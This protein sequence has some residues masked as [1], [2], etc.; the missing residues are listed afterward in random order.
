VILLPRMRILRAVLHL[1]KLILALA[2]HLHLQ[3][4][5]LY[6]WLLATLRLLYQVTARELTAGRRRIFRVGGCWLF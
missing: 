6:F 1:H 5:L 2:S 3:C 4:V